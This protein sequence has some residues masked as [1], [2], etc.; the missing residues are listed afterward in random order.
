MPLL[1]QLH[2]LI[3]G[4][5]KIRG[6]SSSRPLLQRA[7]LVQQVEARIENA[8]L[9]KLPSQA[10]ECDDDRIKLLEQAVGSLATKQQSLESLVKDNASTQAQQMHSLQ[11]QI[12]QQ[13]QKFHGSME[14]HKQDIQAMFQNQMTQIRSLLSKRAREGDDS[15]DL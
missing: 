1:L 14:T 9:S 5:S 13:E 11:G 7:T 3:H 10:M 12:T 8:V 2:L 6:P 4:W 15:M